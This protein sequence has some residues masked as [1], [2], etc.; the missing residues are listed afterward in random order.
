MIK[1][2]LVFKIPNIT[3]YHN[4]NVQQAHKN[5]K[6]FYEKWRFYRG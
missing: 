5:F 2:S 6:Q 1:K 4:I 3:K